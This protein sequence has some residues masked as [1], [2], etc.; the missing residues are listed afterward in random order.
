[1]IVG[2]L[3]S[4]SGALAGGVLI[5]VSEALAGFYVAPSAKTMFS[6]SL[7]I[8]VLLFRPRGLLGN[9]L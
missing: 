9:K 7:L 6:F 1:V 2:G 4:M 5:G 3:G 8:L